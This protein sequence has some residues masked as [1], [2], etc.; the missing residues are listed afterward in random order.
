LIKKKLAELSW[1]KAINKIVNLLPDNKVFFYPGG[2]LF[3]ALYK[4][5]NQ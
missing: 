5:K 1:T 4:R 2:D 3:W